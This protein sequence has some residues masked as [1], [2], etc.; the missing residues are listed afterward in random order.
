L[1]GLFNYEGVHVLGGLTKSTFVTGLENSQGLLKRLGSQV[2][3]VVKDFGTLFTLHREDRAV[4][5]QQLR[6]IYDGY[7]KKE[8]GNNKVEVWEGTIGLLGACTN[9]IENFHG[10]IG[11]LGNRY[12]LYRCEQQAE[13]RSEIAMMALDDEGSE[14]I[15]RN[16]ISD[17]FVKALEASPYT[18]SVTIPADIKGKIAKLSNL[19]SRLRSPV[20]RAT[21][22]T[23]T[24]TP[25]I[26]GPA[27]LA[28]AF[29]KLG[30]GLAAV[31]GKRDMS[32]EEY[33][34]LKRVVV[35]TLPRRRAKILRYLLDGE[36]RRTKEV[37][38]ECGLPQS[39]ATLAL[40]DMAMIE[41]LNRTPDVPEGAQVQQN[42]PYK[43]QLRKDIL[44]LIS[45]SELGLLIS[46]Y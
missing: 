21:D 18:K 6:E 2:T 16:E 34:T 33:E 17:A 39:T 1:R 44:E 38:S 43:W 32:T 24:H 41:A 29:S 13:S 37:S 23:V 15:M 7:Y 25:D 35:D 10:V 12:V 5:L 14:V 45:L 42:T 9:G 31:R 26:E 19:A 11:E 28:K 4:V 46:N 3:L 36:Y 20:S 22:K 8:W 30:K 40:E 27:R